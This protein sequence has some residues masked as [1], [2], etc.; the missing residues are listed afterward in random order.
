M[1]Y[2]YCEWRKAQTPFPGLS[3]WT[4][5]TVDGLLWTIIYDEEHRNQGY[6]LSYKRRG[7]AERSDG[8]QHKTLVA[9]QAAQFKQQQS[10]NPVVPYRGSRH[11][12]RAHA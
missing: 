7:C 5:A 12:K 9:A 11:T 3:M 4:M 2:G 8:K 1:Q 6:V 10:F